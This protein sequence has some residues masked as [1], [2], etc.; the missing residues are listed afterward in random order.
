MVTVI[1]KYTSIQLVVF[2]YT[3]VNLSQVVYGRQ[4]YVL[5]KRQ[6]LVGS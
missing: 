6:K 4:N 5:K 1:A 3:F 2:E